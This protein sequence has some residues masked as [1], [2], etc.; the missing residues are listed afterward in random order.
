[1]ASR[2]IFLA[3]AAAALL[4]VLPMRSSADEKTFAGTWVITGNLANPAGGEDINPTCKFKVDGKA[5]SGSCEG[6]NGMGA[7][8]GSVDGDKIVFNWDRIAKNDKVW[9]AK[10]TFRGEIGDDGVLRGQW[11]DSTI[12][13]TVGT[14]V[15]QKLK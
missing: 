15:G 11:K 2:H 10:L 6:R 8:D 9:D 13:D 1:M 14:F 5:V 4:I 12:D 3:G 7:V